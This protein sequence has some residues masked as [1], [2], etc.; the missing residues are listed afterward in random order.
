MRFPLSPPS[1]AGAAGAWYFRTIAGLDR[2]P[3]S[4]SYQNLIIRPPPYDDIIYTDANLSIS[5]AAAS[6]DSSMGMVSSAWNTVPGGNGAQCGTVAENGVLDL[7]CPGGVFTGVSFASFGT[8]AGA[9][10]TF[11]KGSCDAAS[12]VDVVTKL[13]VG[14]ASC[15]I[16]ANNGAF[17]GDPCFDTPKTLAVALAGQCGAP[18]GVRKF[19]LQ[20]TVPVGGAAQV[21]VPAWGPVSS[22]AITEGGAKVWAAGAFVPGTAG[23]TAGAASADGKAVVFTVASG[24]YS[25]IV[26]QVK[27][28]VARARAQMRSARNER[29]ERNARAK[30]CSA[31]NFRSRVLLVAHGRSMRVSYRNP[32]SPL[33]APVR[34]A[35]NHSGGRARNNHGAEARRRRRA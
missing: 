14:K 13:C 3:S 25:F 35:V 17:G 22:V 19:S 24:T 11:T 2:A 32:P 15:S 30:A 5:W 20:T 18:V 12:S 29:N 23:V 27:R 6:I 34:A 16:P 21:I 4:R 7:E 9:C 10:P 26:Y 33:P 31:R 28:T 1:R 8:P